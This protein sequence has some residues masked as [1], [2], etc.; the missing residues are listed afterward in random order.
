MNTKLDS[1]P[2]ERLTVV[3]GG[4]GRAGKPEEEAQDPLPGNTPYD[5]CHDQVGG[6]A[7]CW[8]QKKAAIFG[9]NGKLSHHYSYP[10]IGTKLGVE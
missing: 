7:V 4:A 2:F 1:I 5:R 9:T 8:G 6:G 10:W 3:L